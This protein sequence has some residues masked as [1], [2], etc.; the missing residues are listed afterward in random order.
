MKT[1]N[2]PTQTQSAYPLMRQS[3]RKYKT[4]MELTNGI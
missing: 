4:I 2:A 1:H 3:F